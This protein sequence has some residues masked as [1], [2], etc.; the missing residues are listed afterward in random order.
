MSETLQ[1]SDFSSECELIDVTSWHRPDT[2]WV[3]VDTYGHEHR[4]H[5]RAKDGTLSV[6]DAYNPRSRYELPTLEQITDVEAT[7]EHPGV[8]HHECRLCRAVVTPGYRADDCRQQVPGLRN[9]YVRGESVSQE[10]F[11][12]RAREAFPDLDIP[13]PA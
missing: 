9:Y 4:W 10:E 8:Y 12:R 7:D 11:I 13:D 1:M 5:V 2:A 6:A 3:H